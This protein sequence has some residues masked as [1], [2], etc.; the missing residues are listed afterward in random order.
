MKID[1]VSLTADLVRCP[2]VTPEEGGAIDLLE[3]LLE[4]NGFSC[5]RIVRG[6]VSNLFAKWGTGRNGRVFGFNGHTDVVP[7]GDL[8]SWTV[9]PFGAEIKEGYL[10]GRGATDMKSGV[11]AF[12]ASAIDFVNNKPPDGSIVITITG[13]EEGEAVD[14]TV[15]ILDWMQQNGE[16]IDH[17][18]VGEPTSPSQMGE[19][20]KIGRRGSMNAKITAIGIQGHSAYPDRANNPIV[21]MVKLLDKLESHQL[22][23]GTEH[24]DPSTLA[25]TSVDTG[26]KASNVI[27]AVTKAAVN[28]RF[29]DSHSGSSL[30][31]WLKDEIEKVSAEYGIK[32]ETDFKISGESFITPPGELSDLISEAVKK[33]LGVTPK[34]STTGGTSDARFI[35]DMCPVTEFGLVGKT[36]HAVDEKVETKQINQ[37]KEIYYRILEAYFEKT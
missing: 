5:T 21:A 25:I 22:D 23:V 4:K 33:E 34:L 24:F 16:K 10:Y 15:A 6:Q 12:V 31:S 1:P 8:S 36:M 37:L 11:A 32:F 18:L 19:M 13:D 9:D 2:S 14:G 35:K 28:I 3:Q 29:N 20:M 26:N 17:C 30:V 27:P 7:V